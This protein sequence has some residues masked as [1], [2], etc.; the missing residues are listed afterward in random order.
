M[1]CD[2]CSPRSQRR[3]RR[4]PSS[5]RPSRSNTSP[6]TCT[7]PGS[8]IR[9]SSSA[10]PASNGCRA[11]SCG[12]RST[13]STTSAKRYGPTSAASTSSERYVRTVNGN[14]ASV[15]DAALSHV[16]EQSRQHERSELY[17]DDQGDHARVRQEEQQHEQRLL[18]GPESVRH[19]CRHQP[20]ERQGEPGEVVHR[21]VR[22]GEERREH[23]G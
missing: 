3:V 7:P 14:V 21:V 17:V 10:R 9:T 13:P 8:P 23:K 2:R 6:T 4:S 5:L 18:A 15:A 1:P 22:R 12:S 20:A 11:S 16:P 19:P